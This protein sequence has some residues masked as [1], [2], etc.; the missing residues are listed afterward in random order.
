MRQTE[1]S[2][3]QPSEA[4]PSEEMQSRRRVLL[5]GPQ[6]L[7]QVDHEPQAVHCAQDAVPVHCWISFNFGHF[8]IIVSSEYGHHYALFRLQKIC[9]WYEFFQKIVA[10]I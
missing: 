1:L 4:Y 10:K 8:R 3:W 2:P 6:S 9:F 5:P 7:S